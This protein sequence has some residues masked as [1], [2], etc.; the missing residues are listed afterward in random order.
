LLAYVKL[1]VCLY[2]TSGAFVFGV[3]GAVAWLNGISLWR[4]LV[5]IKDEILITFA[6]AST[7]TVLPRMVVKLEAMGCSKPVVGLV[8][9]AGYTFNA[10]GGCIYLTMAALFLAQAT[11][12]SLSLRDQVL[13]VAVCLFTSKGSA[14]V[15]GA[16]FVALAATLSSM[17]QVPVASLVLLVGVDRFLNEARA[18]TNLIGNGIA[19]VA[20]ARWEGELDGEKAREVLARGAAEV[21][22]PA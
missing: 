19:T 11:D 13:I 7:E 3:L 15:A 16:A 8:L 2:V 22:E 10:D 20:V 4:F 1:L 17:H 9:P 5:Y 6:T 14:G 21:V 18:V 12:T